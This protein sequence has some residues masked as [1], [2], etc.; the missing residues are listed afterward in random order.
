[1]RQR[2]L[3]IVV[4]SRAKQR[5]VLPGRTDRRML[6]QFKVRYAVAVDEPN[7]GRPISAKVAALS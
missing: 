2:G 4:E 5:E 1:M 7:Q 3:E 6:N